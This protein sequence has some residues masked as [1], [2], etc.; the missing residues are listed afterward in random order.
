MGWVKTFSTFFFCF[1]SCSSFL[2]YEW[3]KKVHP[4]P[5][6]PTATELQY[7]YK[8]RVTNLHTSNIFDLSFAKGHL[9][10]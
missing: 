8:Q 9:Y 4:A 5:A 6:F 2:L 7:N 10:T 1:I 3:L